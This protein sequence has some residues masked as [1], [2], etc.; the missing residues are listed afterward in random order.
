MV[1]VHLGP[2]L[3]WTP[4]W[5]DAAPAPGTQ[6]LHHDLGADGTHSRS[7]RCGGMTLSGGPAG[8]RPAHPS[9]LEASAEPS[10]IS[11][12]K[13]ASANATS[14][15]TGPLRHLPGVLQFIFADLVLIA[16]PGQTSCDEAVDAVGWR[17]SLPVNRGGLLD[18]VG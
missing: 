14:V 17:P 16:H 2:L 13:R 15:G 11:P 5:C 9:R 6:C 4:I 8:P 7:P 3:R 18:H 10:S 12:P 1:Q